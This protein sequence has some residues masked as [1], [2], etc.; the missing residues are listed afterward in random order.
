MSSDVVSDALTS[1]C[2]LQ[3]GSFWSHFT[4]SVTY[5]RRLKEYATASYVCATARNTLAF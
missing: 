2:V 5:N 1:I 4:S 3:F